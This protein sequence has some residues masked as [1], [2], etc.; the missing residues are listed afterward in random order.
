MRIILLETRGNGEKGLFR[1]PDGNEIVHLRFYFGQGH[2][3]IEDDGRY[4]LGNFECLPIP[5]QDT[6]LNSATNSNRN[7]S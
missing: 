4:F 5:D 1:N 2:G 3:L 7:R 6:E